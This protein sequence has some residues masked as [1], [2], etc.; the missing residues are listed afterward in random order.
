MAEL[1][2]FGRVLIITGLAIAGLGLLLELVGRGV[3]PGLGRLP[4]DIYVQ[5]GHFRF[6]LPITTSLL[7]S[8]ILTLILGLM[9][10]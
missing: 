5:R 10:R 8:L 7:I 9:R 6:Y 2:G 4:G 1:S 3:I